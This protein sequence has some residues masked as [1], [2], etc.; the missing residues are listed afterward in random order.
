MILDVR[1]L[2]PGTLLK[3]NN[4]LGY[5]VYVHGGYREQQLQVGQIVMFLDYE[6]IKGFEPVVIHD[7]MQSLRLKLLINEGTHWVRVSSWYSKEGLPKDLIDTNFA[8]PSFD[9]VSSP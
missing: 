5:Y 1:N 9:V 8:C 7:G 4:L 6:T 3:C 2:K